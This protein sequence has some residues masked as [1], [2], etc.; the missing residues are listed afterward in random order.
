MATAVVFA[1]RY[2]TTGDI[3]HHIAQQLGPDAE[4]FDLADGTPDLS[5]YDL[6]VLGTPVYLG[7][8]LEP[9]K[10]LAGS[11]ALDGKPVA[12]FVGGLETDPARRDTTT[13]QAFPAELLDRAVAVGFLGGRLWSGRIAMT[14]RFA[15]RRATGT[16][17]KADV[18][19]I[20]REAVDRFVSQVRDSQGTP[21]QTR[22]G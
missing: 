13:S 22:P 11:A 15:F 9:M 6:V 14:D 21:D 19:A 7:Q 17:I 3:A 10:Q 4:A 1:S 5:G 12:L 20:D 16:K 18:D 8:P 2:G